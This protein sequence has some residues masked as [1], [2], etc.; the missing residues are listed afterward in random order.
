MWSRI[1]L[2][3][4]K[5][6]EL[7][8]LEVEKGVYSAIVLPMLLEK[9]PDILRL[10]ITRGQNYLDWALR[11]MLNALLVEVERRED[12]CL[13]QPARVTGPNDN[14]RSSQPTESVLFTRRGEDSRCPFCL[15]GHQPEQ[16][17][18]VTNIG[19]RKRLLVKYG[20]CFS[21]TE[22]GHRARDCK[23][24]ASCKNCKGLHY[25]ILC[26]AKPQTPSGKS[27]P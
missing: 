11:D 2:S 26:E 19:N 15:G 4:Q 13:T 12:Q 7:Q 16:C 18:K 3:W 25:A 20:R 9:V 21:C 1:K 27:G 10:T 23:I 24:S 17:K 22:R 6:R 14:R 8:A 5:Y